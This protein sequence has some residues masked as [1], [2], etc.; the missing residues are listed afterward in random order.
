MARLIAVDLG[1]W[2]VKVAVYGGVGTTHELERIYSQRVPGD[3][4]AVA[5][6]GDRLASLDL[7]MRQIKELN[8]AHLSEAVWSTHRTS[9]RRMSM[10]FDDPDQ[11]EQTLPFAIEAEVPFDLDDLLLAWRPSGQEREVLTALAREDDVAAMVHGLAHRGLDPRRL[12]L[13]GEILARRAT[14]D[15]SWAA[16]VDVGHAHTVVTVARDGQ[17]RFVRSLDVAGRS[18]T[19]AIQD[20]LGCTWPE[21]E[22][23]KHGDEEADDEPTGPQL[24]D[25][26]A[27]DPAFHIALPQKAK[28]ALHG[29]I[30]L[31]LAE[32][33]SALIQ[34]EDEL[35]V[36]VEEVVLCGGGSKIA[37]LRT[38]LEQDLGVRVVLAEATDG[39]GAKPG[40]AAVRSLGVAMAGDPIRRLD[41]RV[42]D[43]AYR[44]GLDATSAVFQYGGAFL[45]SFL[46][47]VITVF[48]LQ[49]QT[50]RTEHAAVDARIRE[51]VETAMGEALPA[52]VSSEGAT[53]LLAEVVDEARQEVEFLGD[54]NAVPPTVHELALLS[55]LV[56][57]HD[58]VRLNVDDLEITAGAIRIQGVTEGFAQVDNIG[59][60]LEKSG[61]YGTI[62]ATPG[63]RDNKGKLQFTVNI[64]R[65]VDGEDGETVEEDG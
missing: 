64:D 52:D 40:E 10:P 26:E 43:L 44:S 23:L 9:V 5:T 56:P 49:Y 65:N 24:V 45:G 6:L 42:G 51:T 8:E 32:I 36:S 48:G 61:R 60:A 19:R 13:D 47:A 27:T 55:K 25:E 14:S 37:E 22:R 4:T 62:E 2:A 17:A 28:E 38:W 20:A 54:A 53:T 58:Q 15:T 12:V 46:V 7:L 50:L 34:A 57:E 30:G 29:A 1:A 3:G 33:R 59:E 11:I 35:G 21:A 16:V 31:L 39:A 41:L 63:N 18:F